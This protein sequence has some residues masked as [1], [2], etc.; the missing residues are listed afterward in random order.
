MLFT[1]AQRGDEIQYDVEVYVDTEDMGMDMD[2]G[3]L[4]KGTEGYYLFYPDGCNF[5]MNAGDIMILLK[6]LQELNGPIL[7]AKTD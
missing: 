1:E 7:K 5:P 6:K 2:V 4:R 3:T